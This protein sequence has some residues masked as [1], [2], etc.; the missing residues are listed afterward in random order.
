MKAKKRKRGDDPPETSDVR[1][2]KLERSSTRRTTVEAR[3][4]TVSDGDMIGET[5]RVELR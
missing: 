3:T 1:K 2:F 4:G 5:M